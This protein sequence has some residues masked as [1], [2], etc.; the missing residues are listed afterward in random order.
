MVNKTEAGFTVEQQLST[1]VERLTKAFGDRL[2]SVI[3]YGSAAS[4][5]WNQ[6]V[7]DLNILCVLDRI[8]RTELQTAQPILN[9]WREAGNP[10]PLLLTA[11]EVEDSTDCFPMEFRDMQQF[12]KVLTGS[13]AIAGI[14]IDQKYY[15][16]QVEHEMRAKQLRL[17]QHAA[18]LLAEP[19]RLHRL[20]VDSVSTFC[21]LGRHALILQG[22]A[23]LWRKQEI[24]QALELAIGT[25]LAGIDEILAIRSAKRSA[26]EEAAA[27]LLDRYL[28]DVEALVRFVDRLGTN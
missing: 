27:D 9:W 16:A 14:S 4:E 2:S 11:Q 19:E 12:R 3:L 26:Q 7:S 20:M 25:P 5:D 13:D 23:P 22:Q 28:Q 21:V 17:R 18:Q 8:S 15:R 6:N 24:V 1:L 10:A